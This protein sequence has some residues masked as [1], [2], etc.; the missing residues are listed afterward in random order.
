MMNVK[1]YSWLITF[2][3][4]KVGAWAYVGGSDIET[5]DVRASEVDYIS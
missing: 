1:L 2:L 5:F 4:D 3:E